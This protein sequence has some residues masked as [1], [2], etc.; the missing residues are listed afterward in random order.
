MYAQQAKDTL[1]YILSDGFIKLETRIYIEP[2]IMSRHSNHEK[3]PSIVY[4]NGT[5]QYCF[6]PVSLNGKTADLNA[7]IVFTRRKEG[8]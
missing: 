2:F 5:V 8:K 6:M 1:Q 3:F 7:V 4:T